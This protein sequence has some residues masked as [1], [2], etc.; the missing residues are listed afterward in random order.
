VTAEPFPGLP[1]RGRNYVERSEA[2]W[3]PIA[4]RLTPH[5]LRHS[6]KTWMVEDRIPEVLRHEVLGHELAG[7]GSRHTRDGRHAG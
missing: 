2:C 1:L 3:V 4:Q 6:H 7:V 5:L